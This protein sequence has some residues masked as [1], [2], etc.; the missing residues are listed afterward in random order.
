LLLLLDPGDESIAEG[1]D[2]LDIA[3]LF[4]VVPQLPAQLAHS[5]IQH[6]VGHKRAVPDCVD[7]LAS[8][9][10]AAPVLNQKNQ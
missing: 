2:C 4:G 1:R 8:A 10:Q 3:R 6:V 5:A 7:Q 9:Y